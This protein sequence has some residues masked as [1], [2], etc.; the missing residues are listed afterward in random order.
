MHMSTSLVLVLGVAII[1]GVFVFADT[2]TQVSQGK[3]AGDGAI[4]AN[5]TSVQAELLVR[6]NPEVWNAS[7]GQTAVQASHQYIGATVSM[8]YSELGLTGLQLVSLPP[9]MTVDQGIAYYE[10]LPY[11]LYAEPNA[12][13]SIESTNNTSSDQKKVTSSPPVPADNTTTTPVRLLVQFNASAFTDAQDLSVYAN[14]TH[15][16]LNATVL[17]DYT[18][19]G[20]SGLYLVAVPEIS[21]KQGIEQYKNMTTVVFV[22]PD[23][24]VGMLHNTEKLE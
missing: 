8:N 10:S 18:A 16:L 22:E 17:K 24:Q 2:I 23:Y 6:F 21:E 1:L 19:E 12:V 4:D 15:Q 3:A 14:Q 9:G 11:V 5:N 7:I 20:L 13:Y